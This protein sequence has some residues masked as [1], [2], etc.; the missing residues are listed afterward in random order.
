MGRAYG[1]YGKKTNAYRVL[2][3][4]LKERDHFN[5]KRTNWDGVDCIHLVQMRDKWQA[6]VNMVNKPS[7]AKRVWEFLDQ[8][9]TVSFS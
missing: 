9:K 6:L 1:I 5:L 8:L 4:S 2:V 7:G 3:R